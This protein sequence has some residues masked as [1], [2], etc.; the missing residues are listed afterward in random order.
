MNLRKE[1]EDEGKIYWVAANKV[2][3]WLEGYR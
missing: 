2:Y 1:M 3:V